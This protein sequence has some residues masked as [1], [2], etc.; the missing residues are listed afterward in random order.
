M[1]DPPL[2]KILPFL[3]AGQNA[4]DPNDITALALDDGCKALARFETQRRVVSEVK[5]GVS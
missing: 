1:G 2:G 3:Q 5:L 4:F